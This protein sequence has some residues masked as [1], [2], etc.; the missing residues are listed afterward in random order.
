MIKK[1]RKVGNSS[2]LILDRALLEVVG[3]REGAQVQITV[4]EGAI[5]IT[6]ANP[7]PV[8]REKFEASLNK[9]VSQRKGALK[10]LAQ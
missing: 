5:V 10:R 1:L 6:P 3:L 2:A 7:R 8:D 4:N 9:V